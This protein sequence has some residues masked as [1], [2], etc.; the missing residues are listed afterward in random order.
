VVR[1]QAGFPDNRRWI[2]RRARGFSLLH[3]NIWIWS[4]T[5][6][7]QR[8]PRGP[9]QGS[10]SGRGLKTSPHLHLLS[11]LT[12]LEGVL[13]LLHKY[14]L[15]V[16]ELSVRPD[17]LCYSDRQEIRYFNATERVYPAY[18]AATCYQQTD[19]ARVHECCEVYFYTA[20]LQVCNMCFR[21]C[22]ALHC[23]ICCDEIQECEYQKYP[24]LWQ[25]LEKNRK[26]GHIGKR[27]PIY[28]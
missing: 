9:F 5:W 12:T 24:K 14:S 19:V 17:L 3:R 7:L 15:R 28:A 26:Y 25:Y 20:C 2:F 21:L 4:P 18:R 8:G 13:L 16:L 27:E 10:Y 6:L 23:W 11:P 22:L 1:L